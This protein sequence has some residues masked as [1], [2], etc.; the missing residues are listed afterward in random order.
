MET[1]GR[2]AAVSNATIY[3]GLNLLHWLD[4]SVG[5]SDTLLMHDVVQS[6]HD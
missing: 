6:I 4:C 2:L 3:D 1:I 5:V